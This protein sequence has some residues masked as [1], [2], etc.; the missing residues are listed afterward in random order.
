M[1]G[2]GGAL[3]FGAVFQSI[4]QRTKTDP[5]YQTLGPD[6]WLKYNL[7]EMHMIFEAFDGTMLVSLTMGLLE[8]DTGKL[9][10]LNAEH[11]P[12]VLYRKGKA[13]YL[14]ADV[15]YR[16][17][18]TLGAMPIQNIKEF[19]LQPGDVLIIGSDGKDDVLRLDANGKWEVNSDD[20]IFLHLVESTEGNLL[21]ITKQIESLGQVIDDISLIR[22]CY[23]P[24][25][26]Q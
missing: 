2:A 26:K 3:V 8:E 20:E 11:P 5:G 14:Q 13:E 25:S 1:Q 4:V 17:L 24:K 9:Y 23:L 21:A 6:D 10:F 7:Q 15:S 19:P 16:K 12:I 18:G 22:I